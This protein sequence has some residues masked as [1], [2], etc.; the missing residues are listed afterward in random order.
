MLESSL[1]RWVG[2]SAC[3]LGAP[4]SCALDVRDLA[5]RVTSAGAAGVA[6]PAPSVQAGAGGAAG[7]AVVVP[8]LPD[9]CDF[10]TGVPDGC[11]TVVDNPGFDTGT[12]PWVAEVGQVTLS[13]NQSDALESKG[14]GSL[15]VINSMAGTADGV[16]SRGA[17]QCLAT[18]PGQVYGLAADLF[19]PG[20]QGDGADGETFVAN[21]GLGMIFYDTANCNGMTVGSAT[22]DLLDETGKWSHREGKAIAPQGAASVAMRLLALKNFR[23][24]R[25][26]ARFDNIL[27]KAF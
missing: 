19:I 4:L 22:S 8:P 26:E 3:L 21:A 20:G 7:S 23:Q 18:T 17:V 15:S 10:S 25:F 6:G 27:V 9:D 12:P 11:E 13:W 24:Y 5:P 1:Y 16:A 2:V 14:S